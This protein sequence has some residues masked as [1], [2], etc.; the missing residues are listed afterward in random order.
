MKIVITESA[1]EAIS[2]GFWFYENQRE[3]LGAHFWN[4]IFSI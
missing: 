4:C 2:D 3:G 1:F